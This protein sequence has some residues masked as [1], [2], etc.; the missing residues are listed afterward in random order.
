MTS[1]G[2][3][4]LAEMNVSN[5]IGLR[6]PTRRD[7]LNELYSPLVPYSSWYLIYLIILDMY[8]QKCTTSFVT[9]DTF[10]PTC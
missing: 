7:R 10:K 6:M 4:L 3:K 8:S 2:V 5:T 1:L 9:K